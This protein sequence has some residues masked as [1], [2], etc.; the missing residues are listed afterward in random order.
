MKRLILLMGV[1]VALA[2][3]GKDE[4]DVVSST[5]APDKPGWTAIKAGGVSMSVPA[6]L[7]VVDLT[8]DQISDSLDNLAK[9]LPQFQ[10]VAQIVRNLPPNVRFTFIAA[11]RESARTGFASNVNVV[12]EVVPAGMGFQRLAD[13]N[14]AGL[15]QMLGPGKLTRSPVRLPAGEA[16]RREFEMPVVT[17]KAR[18]VAYLLMRGTTS[19]N[20]TFTTAPGDVLPVDEIMQT[21]RFN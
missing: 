9:D 12:E 1:V 6:E 13:A 20:I 3:C 19:Y 16:E 17:G 21:F 14:A 8:P 11:D 15:E 5:P 7:E 2:G 4:P 18:S 10:E